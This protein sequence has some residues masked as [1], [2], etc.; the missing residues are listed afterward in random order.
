SRGPAYPTDGPR[1]DLLVARHP[2]SGE[3][4]AMLEPRRFWIV[5]GSARDR[6][7][8]QQERFGSRDAI[9]GAEVGR[10]VFGESLSI[11]RQL[12]R[13]P[14]DF[15]FGAIVPDGSVTWFDFAHEDYDGAG[16]F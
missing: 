1:S 10:G 7:T 15:A 13:D 9:E 16:A 5:D 8:A 3:L 11:R 4:A 2:L 6:H 12:G 14:A